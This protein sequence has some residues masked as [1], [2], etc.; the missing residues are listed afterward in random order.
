MADGDSNKLF[1]RF[2]E[3]VN[4]TESCWIWMGSKHPRGYGCFC[5]GNTAT[6]HRYSYEHFVGPIPD[7]LCVCHK[8]DNPSCVN[9]DHLFV[10]THTDNMLDK[11]AKGR[12]NHLV[13]SK[14]PKSKLSEADVLAIR[15]DVRKQIEIAAAF[16]I[17]QAQVSE[18]KRR[19]AW[20]HV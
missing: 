15:A 9:P 17:K 16:G 3:K 19:V 20:S 8:C 1:S 6:A 12:G 5:G 7:G 18:I 11:M 10:G 2:M 14:H 4:K 13:G